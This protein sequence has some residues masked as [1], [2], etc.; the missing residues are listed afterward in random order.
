MQRLVA[1][2]AY[3]LLPLSYA[4][5][6]SFDQ[7]HRAWT[8]LLRQHVVLLDG[9]GGSRVR[10]WRGRPLVSHEVIINL[11][12][13]TTTRTRSGSAPT[14]QRALPHRDHGQRRGAGCGQSATRRLPWRLELDDCANAK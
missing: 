11:I 14:G 2:L 3:T 5:G 12:A 9:G 4:A 13:S 8:D 6:W 10:N 7:S 1:I